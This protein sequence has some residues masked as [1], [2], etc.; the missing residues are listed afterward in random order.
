MLDD[1][2]ITQMPPVTNGIREHWDKY[3]YVYK[4]CWEEEKKANPQKPNCLAAAK[5]AKEKIKE[6]ESKLIQET[7]QEEMLDGE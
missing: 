2:V 1:Y 3:D 5:K 7:K 6:I 4:N